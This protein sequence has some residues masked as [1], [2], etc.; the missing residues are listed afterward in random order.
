MP[1]GPRGHE[2][3][4]E[5]SDR[6]DR[7]ID[8]D[9]EQ[10]ARERFDA[11]PPPSPWKSLDEL[12]RIEPYAGIPYALLESL[13]AYRDRGRPV[14]GFLEA[15]LA[16]D[17][18]SAVGYADPESLAAFRALA[19]FVHCQMPAGAHGSRERVAE[20]RGIA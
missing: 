18:R 20:W 5:Y 9:R 14:G 6:Q 1:W 3:D 19:T 13:V 17:L 15:F 2:S 11:P 8:Y 7:M 16:N 4:A 10:I 12:Q